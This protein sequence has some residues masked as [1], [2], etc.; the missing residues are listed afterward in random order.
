MNENINTN[1][2]RF[3]IELN[4]RQLRA[5]DYVCNNYSRI[6]CGQ[7]DTT[8]LK[9]CET[10]WLINHEGESANFEE[11]TKMQDAAKRC[12]DE[13]VDLC[14]NGSRG[15]GH[16]DYSDMIFDM[17]SVIQHALWLAEP[18][19]FRYKLTVAAD[20]PSALS[21]EPLITV[22]PVKDGI[23]DSPIISKE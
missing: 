10:A 18:E 17:H 9:E 7:L 19:E 13:L 20:E 5:L 6:I 11:L 1:S 23:G 3:S 16:C 8:V 4:D 22:V 14:W 2:S 12:C 21:S 15:A